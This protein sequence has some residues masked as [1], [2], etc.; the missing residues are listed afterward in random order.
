MKKSLL[1]LGAILVCLSLLFAF[2][3]CDEET[4]E[5][6]S[7]D[8]NVEESSGITENEWNS[9]VAATVFENY[10]LDLF[11]DMT[12]YING[13]EQLGGEPLKE[14]YRVTENAIEISLIVDGEPTY[15][16]TLHDDEAKVT[17]TELA[18]IFLAILSDYDN[19]SYNAESGEY[20]IGETEITVEV[21]AIVNG[22]LSGEK[23]PITI[24][25]KNG[26]AKLSSDGKVVN[27]VCE[28]SQSM[29]ING[30]NMTVTGTTEWSFSNY[31]TTTIAQ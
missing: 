24:S 18:Q 30:Q 20:I 21:T 11:G 7:P 1:K 29:D 31:G 25:V 19:F 16:I 8:K 28:Y 14:R 2:V 4:E 26:S 13:V 10:T 27:L 17:K 3:S 6:Q 5:P 23:M 15:T 12:T 22:S 9:A